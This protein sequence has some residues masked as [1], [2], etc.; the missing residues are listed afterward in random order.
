[1]SKNR[2]MNNLFFLKNQ[3]TFAKDIGK[4]TV[5]ILYKTLLSH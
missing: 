1:M 3:P 5:G 4:N 2:V